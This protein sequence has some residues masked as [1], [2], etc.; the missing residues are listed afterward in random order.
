MDSCA[1]R[2]ALGI[3]AAKTDFCA[4][5]KAFDALRP[6]QKIN[7][8]TTSL[9]DPEVRSTVEAM[10]HLFNIVQA[11]SPRMREDEAI[12]Q[13]MLDEARLS[14]EPHMLL[15]TNKKERFEYV[16]GRIPTTHK[17]QEFWGCFIDARGLLRKTVKNSDTTQQAA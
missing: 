17:M 14:R 10:P 8:V 13:A 6:G 1:L 15:I 9:Y 2:H 12:F 7:V 3:G 5:L 11:I 16:L 4:N